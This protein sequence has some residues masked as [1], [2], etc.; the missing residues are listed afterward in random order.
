[1]KTHRRIIQIIIL[2][3]FIFLFLKTKYSG[4][5]Y[6]EYPL[7]IFLALDPLIA[8]GTMISSRTFISG[9][10]YSFLFVIATVILG[11]FFCGW[12]CPL[13]TIIDIFDYIFLNKKSAAGHQLPVTSCQLPVTSHEIK[14]D[15]PWDKFIN[16]KY[17]I[18]IFIL[19]G[20]I[21]NVQ[22]IWLFDPISILFRTFTVSLYP[23]FDFI[24]RNIFDFFYKTGLD[25]ISE[26][27]FGVLKKSVLSL[28]PLVYEQNIFILSF[29]LVI[30]ILDII[31][32]R[33][34]CRVIC[35]LGGLFELLSHFSLVKK[36]IDKKSCNECNLCYKKC[37]TG[38]SG[39]VMCFN[40]VDICH[41]GAI[42][43][44]IRQKAEGRRQK[45][46]INLSRRVLITGSIS[47]AFLFP[48]FK[49]SAL[50][51]DKN[52]LLIRP[53]G[54]LP[55]NEFLARCTRCGECM[56]VCVT[57]GLNPA[58]LEA[59]IYSLWSPKLVPRLG[60]CE[61]NC[62]LCGQVCPTGAIEELS[63]KRKHDTKIGMAYIDRNRCIPWKK[64]TDCLVCEEHCPVPDKAIKFKSTEVI[65]LAGN[66]VI[67]KQPHVIEKLCIGCGIC[68]NKCPIQKSAIIIN[69]EIHKTLD[70]ILIQ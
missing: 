3:L 34:W 19:I 62:T 60:Y 23:L 18:L 28:K 5:N 68:E 9:L 51:K 1:M 64:Y 32:K 69:T 61:Y 70:K 4:K 35:P 2:I 43:F 29:F 63:I 66:K 24:T 46:E 56:R 55:E 52:Y 38:S 42:S 45:A 17:Y 26:P 13:G 22:F 12:F 65:N 20:A 59:G 16:I 10:F 11:R 36:Y 25:S 47:T 58:F 54:A 67:V 6:L 21:I 57:N 33:F 41:S 49:L 37:K 14:K 30:F 50:L 39:C 8:L 44:N 40:C 53:P 7:N 48:T 27:V 31:G 15:F